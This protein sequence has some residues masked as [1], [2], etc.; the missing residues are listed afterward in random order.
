MD[1]QVPEFQVLLTE[2]DPADEV[3]YQPGSQEFVI[4]S[5]SPG[6][7]LVLQPAGEPESRLVPDVLKIRI[8]RAWVERLAGLLRDSA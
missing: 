1:V 8:S 2:F 5:P 3:S 7:L 6:P 4:S